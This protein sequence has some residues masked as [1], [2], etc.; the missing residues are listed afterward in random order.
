M[1]VARAVWIIV[2]GGLGKDYHGRDA[3]I[4]HLLGPG[5][6]QIL[7]AVFG[8]GCLAVCGAY[9]RLLA[10]A[11]RL[12]VRADDDG[13]SINGTCGHKASA[14]NDVRAIT[15]HATRTRSREIHFIK[16][17]ARGRRDVLVP[18]TTL[19]GGRPAVETW[20]DQAQA[21]LR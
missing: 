8:V 6:T 16:I 18:I 15:L 11:D 3:G 5:G 13:L 9:L 10:R 1:F 19:A 12:A 7:F 2:S 17:A 14:W 4:V 20:I 21:H